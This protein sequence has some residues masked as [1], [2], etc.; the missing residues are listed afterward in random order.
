MESGR[1]TSEK[2]TNDNAM[3]SEKLKVLANEYESRVAELSKQFS[4]VRQKYYVDSS[5]LSDIGFFF[6]D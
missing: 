5:L 4:E 1:E 2:L 3:L 6:F